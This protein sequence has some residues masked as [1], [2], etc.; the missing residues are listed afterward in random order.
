VQGSAEFANAFQ[1]RGRK[2]TQGRTLR[3]FDLQTRLFKYPCSYV[4]YSDAFDQLPAELRS[5][6][7]QRLWNILSE[8]DTRPDFQKLSSN[9][10]RAILEILGETKEGLPKYWSL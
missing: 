3:Q 9:T 10:K 1:A 4:I 5:D 7:Y 2:D 6:I 8:K